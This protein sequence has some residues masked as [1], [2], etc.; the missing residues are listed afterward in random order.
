VV[1]DDVAAYYRAAGARAAR[2]ATAWNALF[3]RYVAEV[4][5][6][7]AELKRRI[8]GALP[9]GWREALPR[10][11][12]ADKAEAT[13]TLS[14]KVLNVL[15]ERMPEI[16]G[17]SAD[18]TP[19]TMTALAK[20][21][22]FQH[23]NYAG[24]YLRFGVREHAMAAVCNGFAAFGGFLPF[25]ATF[26]NFIGYAAGGVRLSALS[27]F[28]V[29]YIATHDS[30]GLGEDGPTHQPVEMLTM[31]RA[32]PNM[33]VLRPADGNETSAA[34]ATWLSHP[35]RPVV[36]ALSRHAL[37]HLPGSSVEA[38]MHGGYTVTTVAAP[39]AGAAAGSTPVAAVVVGVA[40]APDLV[41]AGTGSE[42]SIALDGAKIFAA[43]HPGKR[44]AV[45][46]FPS[47]EVFEAQPLAY[48]KSVLPDGVPVVSVEASAITGWGRYAHAHVGMVRFG[49]SAPHVDV[50]KELGITPDGVAARAEKALAFFAV[51]P[52]P[53][54]VVNA[55]ELADS[56]EGAGA[57]H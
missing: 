18:L 39:D 35:D 40:G 37:P 1:P 42:V 24:R 51:H 29:L 15:A 33:L 19:S 5:D 44:V 21:R 23:G 53:V 14:G 22:D 50:Y 10:F 52:V 9:D 31:L 3:E 48:R 55:P 12:P 56:A 13:R 8:A 46:S 54:L 45:V 27:H 2:A 36:M 7:G 25:G 20:S 30:I 4:P 41:V 43:R 49:A 34:Y 32:T 57:G 47:L 17:G 38:A 16:I 11:S 6:A 26:L 28:R